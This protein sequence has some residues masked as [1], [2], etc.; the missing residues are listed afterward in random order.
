MMNKEEKYRDEIFKLVID[1]LENS[2]TL[3]VKLLKELF[4]S[5]KIDNSLLIKK[6]K[7]L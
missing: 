5:E 6:I 1:T 7:D 2:E 4:L 3:E